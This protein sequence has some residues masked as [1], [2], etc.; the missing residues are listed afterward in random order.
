MKHAYY[1]E[2]LLVSDP[3]CIVDVVYL[4]QDICSLAERSLDHQFEGREKLWETD[5]SGFVFIE[6]E[7]QDLS[8]ESARVEKEVESLASD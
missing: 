1:F 4:E 3:S 2:Q 8:D 7:E 5:G 6:L